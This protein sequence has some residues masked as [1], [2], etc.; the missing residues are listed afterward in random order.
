MSAIL[1]EEPRETDAAEGEVTWKAASSA[2]STQAGKEPFGESEL[3][4]GRKDLSE[5]TTSCLKQIL[6]FSSGRRSGEGRCDG[7][8]SG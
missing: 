1:G 6:D 3:E 8:A 2:R 5:G 4:V 7:L